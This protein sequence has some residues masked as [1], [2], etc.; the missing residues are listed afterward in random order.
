MP[1]ISSSLSATAKPFLV[2]SDSHIFHLLKKFNFLESLQLRAMHINDSAL[3][4][5]FQTS[6]NFV[7]QEYDLCF[8]TDRSNSSVPDL[9]S[10][11]SSLSI[12]SMTSSQSSNL[13]TRQINK[14]ARA[15]AWKQKQLEKK[16]TTSSVKSLPIVPVKSQR[17]TFCCSS[18][19]SSKSRRPPVSIISV[20]PP[21]LTTFAEDI[22]I[23]F[24]PVHKREGEYIGDLTKKGFRHGRGHM[25]YT[26]PEFS[27]DT[28]TGKWKLDKFYGYGK[29]T[30][31]DGT[32]YEGNWRTQK[33]HGI[34]VFT[35]PDG[36]FYS[37]EFQNDE[38]HGRGKLVNVGGIVSEGIFKH[39]LF[40]G[41]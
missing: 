23:P 17:K 18:L 30:W 34:G 7:Y 22:F 29:Y 26:C 27:G 31:A 36:S 39:D 6:F 10:P 9:T 20:Q 8:Q 5:E 24:I 21:I 35:F 12:S 13:S 3:I 11:P 32:V 2:E 4:T 16:S 1:V 25:V 38:F 37:G 19:I 28:Y 14:R 15:Q 41:P 40:I 33:R